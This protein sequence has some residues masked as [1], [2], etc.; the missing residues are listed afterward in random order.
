MRH[1]AKKTTGDTLMDNYFLVFDI[2]SSTVILEDLQSQGTL[3][4]YSSFM[5]RLEA[6]LLR[7]R[8]LHNLSIYKF[9]GDGFILKGR[10]G[11]ADAVLVF[12]LQLIAFGRNELQKLVH[13]DLENE[14]LERVGIT[15]GIDVAPALPVTMKSTGLEYVSRGINMACRLQGKLDK[16]EDVNT[17]LLS[18]KVYNAAKS[19][20]LKR[21][22]TKRSHVFK[23]IHNN[24][25][26]AC[27]QLQMKSGLRDSKGQPFFLLWHSGE[28]H[29][30]SLFD[31]A[32]VCQLNSARY[33]TKKECRKAVADV[34]KAL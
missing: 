7:H 6:F 17:V 22:C 5:Q 24:K 9:T 20:V 3:T 26:V 29:L 31:S 10:L 27:Y 16:P 30:F 18:K 34:R 32:G 21:L 4:V 11:E 14:E 28:H 1:A 33:K 8:K 23:N 19:Q 25:A 2:C 15:V 12:A 13:R